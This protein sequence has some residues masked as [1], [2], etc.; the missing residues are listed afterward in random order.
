MR[1]DRLLSEI[2]IMKPQLKKQIPA[3]LIL[4]F[5]VSSV[6]AKGPIGEFV[7]H[8][9]GVEAL[10]TEL[11]FSEK[12]IQEVETDYE[13]KLYDAAERK[14]KASVP[15]GDWIFSP[16]LKIK[17]IQSSA[18]IPRTNRAIPST[19]WDGRMSGDYKWKLAGTTG[20]G[21]RITGGSASDEPFKSL[22]EMFYD[23]TFYVGAG[24]EPRTTFLFF[25]NVSNLRPLLI[26]W[27]VPG[28]SYGIR[29]SPHW[30]LSLGFPYWAFWAEP[31]DWLKFNLSIEPMFHLDSRLTV[32]PT[33]IFQIF[34]GA[35]ASQE[36]YARKNR[37]YAGEYLIFDD[38]EFNTGIVQDL[39]YFFIELAGSYAPI[40]QIHE[41]RNYL[42]DR[43]SQYLEL[44][45][46]FAGQ[47]SAKIKL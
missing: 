34:L 3:A 30:G 36:L 45:R 6:L 9:T 12:R 42:D 46:G 35:Q 26:N 1:Y 39:K 40:R 5:S 19:L 24:V 37:S 20:A 14:V 7:D 32:I 22:D 4:F 38:F 11:G 17:E 27:P 10:G 47:L 21:A 13:N 16:S 31:F 29:L 25:I 2:R 44:A 15:W 28:V 41:T 8:A 33:R 18:R 43:K 23:A